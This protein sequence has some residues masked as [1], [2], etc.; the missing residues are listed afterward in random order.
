MHHTVTVRYLDGVEKR[1]SVAPDQTLLEAA[2][3]SG[4]AIVS[5]CESGVCGTC[6][7]TCS[8]GR[9]EMGRTEGLSEVERDNRKVLTCQTTMQSDGVL[10]LQYPAGDNAARLLSGEGR[11]TRVERLSPTTAL[12][13]IDASGLGEDIVYQPGQF[14]QLRIPGS[15]VWRSYSY[16]H[17]PRAGGQLEFIVRLLPS[18]V[19]SDYLRGPAKAGDRIALRCSKGGFHL[20]PIRRPVVLVAGGTGLSAILAMAES[21]SDVALDHPVTVLYGVTRYEDLCQQEA[22]RELQQRQPRLSLRTIVAQ[23]DPRWSGPVGVV[24]ALL[25]AAVLNDGNVDIYLCG[26]A[27]MVDATRDWL[28]HAGMQRAGLYFEKFVASGTGQRARAGRRLDLKGLDLAATAL[29]GKGTA[30]VIGGSIAGIAAAKVLSERFQNVIVLEKDGQHDRREGRPGAAQGWHLHHLLTAGQQEIERI[31]PGIIDDMV[32]EGAFKV[33]MAEQYR[34]RLA[35]SWKTPCKGGIEIVCAGRPLLEWCVRRRLDAEPGIEYRYD[36]EMQDLVYD[37]DSNTVLGV[38]VNHSEGL[39]VIPAEF[40]VDA[41]GKNTR[42]PEFLEGM[43]LGRPELEQDI[44]NC[45]YSSMWF[46]VPPERQWKD[47]VMEICFAYRPNEQTYAAQYYVDSSRTLLCSSL[48]EYNCYSPPRNVQEFREFAKRMQ[49][50]LVAQNIEGLEPATPVY[51]FRSPRMQRYHYEKMRRLP[52]ALVAI[53][54]SY[55]STDPVAGL[56]M[57]I[58]LQEV[59]R[60]R[61][62]LARYEP[63]SPELPRRYYRAIARIGDRAWFVIREQTLRFSWIKDVASKRPFYFRALNWY[64]DRTMELVHEDIDAYKKFLAVV[65]LVKPPM[66]LLTPAMVL[67]VVGQWLWTKLRGRKTLIEKNYGAAVRALPEVASTHTSSSSA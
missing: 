59:A 7:G 30:V 3:A 21:L 65:H 27:A 23:P 55:T 17:P 49:S 33:D 26:P 5:E 2:E 52:N 41:S 8:S 53:G 43:G 32:R 6:V 31:F 54:D 60:L 37:A 45:F 28:A 15:E 44:L 50:P 24:T 47:K 62:L 46:H 64:M 12:L 19:M 66:S 36:N 9:Y 22:L 18:G 58:T 51:N 14:A 38:A 34:L 35:G 48:I 11:V 29:A 61:E 16:A 4:V 25:D 57:T 10:E 13:C 42:L 20:R 1:M 39:E 63:M 40:V 67:R 56:G